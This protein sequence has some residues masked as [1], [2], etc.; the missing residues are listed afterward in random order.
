M[1]FLT[2]TYINI[3]RF[4]PLV[5]GG[6]II[7]LIFK[8]ADL[9]I[10]ASWSLSGIVTCILI[11]KG[12]NLIISPL[13]GLFV[14]GLCG[15][16]TIMIFRIIGR[17]KFLAGVISYFLLTAIGFHFLGEKATINISHNLTKFGFSDSYIFSILIYSIYSLLIFVFIVYWQKSKFGIKSRLIG[18]NPFSAK[19]Y[20]YSTDLYFGLGL[21]ISNSIIGLGGGLWVSD[22]G[23]AS[24]VQGIGLVIKAFLA[25]LIGQSILELFG[26]KRITPLIIIVG[27]TLYVLITKIGEVMLTDVNLRFSNSFIKASDISLFIGLIIIFLLHLKQRKSQKNNKVS[28]W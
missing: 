4:L 17:G 21:I 26:Y 5:G 3:V 25:L 7:I 22:F 14:G 6:Y 1:E 13:V 19:Y 10:E 18:E 12:L 16:L 2:N 28:E 23:Y 20:N 27:T 24:N 11:N 8:F 9:T 15:C